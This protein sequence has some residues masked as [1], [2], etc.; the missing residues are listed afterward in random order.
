MEILGPNQTV[1]ENIPSSEHCLIRE[2]FMVFLTET[3]NLEQYFNEHISA[4]IDLTRKLVSTLDL[5]RNLNIC[6]FF[7]WNHSQQ[8]RT[9]WHP[10]SA[11]SFLSCICTGLLHLNT[12]ARYLKILCLAC[13]VCWCCGHFSAADKITVLNL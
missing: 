3:L 4:H 11:P 8:Q 9:S 12:S 7:L 6:S 2:C 13:K 5:F 1:T 10:F